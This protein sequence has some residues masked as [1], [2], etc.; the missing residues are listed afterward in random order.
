MI[1]FNG[2]LKQ[3]RNLIK[4][5]SNS[6]ADFLLAKWD[7]PWMTREPNQKGEFVSKREWQN[8]RNGFRYFVSTVTFE[9]RNL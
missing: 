6:L 5:T 8:L 4:I 9:N 2:E 3:Y 1:L 7:F